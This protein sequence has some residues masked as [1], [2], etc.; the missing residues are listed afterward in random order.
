M[1]KNS[2]THT[3]ASPNALFWGTFEYLPA[4]VFYSKLQWKEAIILKG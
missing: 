4:V 1:L 3:W 2:Q